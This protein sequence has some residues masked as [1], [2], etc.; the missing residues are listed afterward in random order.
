MLLKNLIKDS[1][2]NL[3]KLKI[4]GLALNSKDVKKGFI[5]FAI[6]GNKSNGENYIN[7]AIKNGAIIIICSESCK[8]KS[9]KVHIIKTKKIR[10][11]LSKI[12]SKFYKLKPK[13]I[14]AVTGT[15]GKT[16]VA[17]FFYQILKENNIPVASIGTLGIRYK[18]NWTY[19]SHKE[20]RVLQQTCC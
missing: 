2:K 16:S 20:Q 9:K 7:Q 18:E 19:F 4:K 1:P 12:T 17:D 13:N 11:Y 6:K 10:N 14:I 3:K 5:F 8:F 15:N